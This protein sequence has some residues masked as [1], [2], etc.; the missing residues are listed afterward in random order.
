MDWFG[1]RSISRSSTKHGRH[2]LCLA[3]DILEESDE[4][5]PEDGFVAHAKVPIS[6][7]GDKCDD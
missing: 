3:I 4:S 5:E 1:S 2:Q 6:N 7:R